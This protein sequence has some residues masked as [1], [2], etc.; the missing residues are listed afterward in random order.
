M[1]GLFAE[2]GPCSLSKDNLHTIPNPYSWHNNASVIFFEQP[3]GTGLA[4]LLPG[5]PYPATHLEGAIDFQ[6][7]LNIFFDEIFPGM[8]GLPLHIAG[9][10]FG[11]HY[12]PAYTHHILES[13]R[14][15]H[16]DSFQGNIS[17]I[18]LINAVIDGTAAHL[19]EYELLCKGKTG[20]IF[21]ASTCATMLSLLPECEQ[22]NSACLDTYDKGVCLEATTTCGE[23]IGR[24]YTIEQEAG[25]RSP[26]NSRSLVGT[27]AAIYIE[28]HS[29][30]I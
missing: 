25:L 30:V 27:A 13:R 8:A 20:P 29:S 19:G 10:S 12:V 9:E 26:F 3:A 14:G 17:S 2:M 21:N 28:S 5:T 7:F 22:L 4:T 1:M 15:K 23:G 6:T 16:P 18:I 11:G 24:F